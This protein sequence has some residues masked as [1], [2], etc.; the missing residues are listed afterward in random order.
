MDLQKLENNF[1]QN[2]FNN[3]D[4]IKI[5]FYAEIMKPLLDELNS[6]NKDVYYSENHLKAGGITDA[7]FRNI[8][9]E[10]KKEG[11]FS[12]ESGKFPR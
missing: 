3:E 8:S 12:K 2:V 4:D 1:K 7:T 11:Y 10:Y 5:H 9:F 6:D